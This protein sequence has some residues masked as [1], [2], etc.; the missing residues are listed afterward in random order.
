MADLLIMTHS[1]ETTGNKVTLQQELSTEIGSAV[2]YIY[3]QDRALE[4]F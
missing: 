2:V 3:I 1:A 4:I